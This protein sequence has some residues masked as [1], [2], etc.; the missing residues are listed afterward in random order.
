M[1]RSIRALVFAVPA[2]AAAALLFAATT[3]YANVAVTQVSSDTFTDAQA[4]HHTEVKPD[5]FV[6]GSTIV[7]AFQ[8]GR[9]FGGGA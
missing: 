7:A 9:V 8:I 6:A 2:A 3:A 1:M 4:Q 5:T